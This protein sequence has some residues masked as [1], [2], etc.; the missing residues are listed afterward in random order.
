MIHPCN[1]D[2]DKELHTEHLQ[3]LEES[4]TGPLRMCMPQ[5]MGAG[6]QHE[7]GSEVT[8]VSAVDAK[9]G[10]AVGFTPKPFGQVIAI[11]ELKLECKDTAQTIAKLPPPY[12][13]AEGLKKDKKKNATCLDYKMRYCCK[14][15]KMYR[16]TQL[17]YFD[18][19]IPPKVPIGSSK[20]ELEIGTDGKLKSIKIT[21]SQSRKIRTINNY[22]NAQWRPQILTKE[23]HSIDRR[24]G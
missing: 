10:K 21:F 16:P 11:E 8:Q 9:D 4:Y 19:F 23:M 2:G 1:S 24:W 15:N 13:F 3:R 22:Y 7:G 6:T 12:I 14:S 17:N 5:E 20:S 18:S